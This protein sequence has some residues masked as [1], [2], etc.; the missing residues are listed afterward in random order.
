MRLPTVFRPV[1]YVHLGVS[2]HY[3]P[4]LLSMCYFNKLGLAA[5]FVQ[6]MLVGAP[7]VDEGGSRC[8]S[9]SRDSTRYTTWGLFAAC[10][11]SFPPPNIP[12]SNQD[13]PTR[14]PFI[15]TL[16]GVDWPP[17]LLSPA[18]Q[19]SSMAKENRCRWNLLSLICV[20]DS[21]NLS[22][23]EEVEVLPPRHG[24]VKH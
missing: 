12:F 17:S 1:F 19:Q 10:P 23:V 5:F 24:E 15:R 14:K 4:V 9:T 13:F 18:G 3:Q 16:L 22:K 8:T 21:F 6:N 2:I 11:F 20:S 7:I